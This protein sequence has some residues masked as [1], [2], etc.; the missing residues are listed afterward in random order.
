MKISRWIYPVLLISIL[1]F[2]MTKSFSQ[3]SGSDKL[4]NGSALTVTQWREDADFLQKEILRLHPDPFYKNPNFNREKFDWMFAELRAHLDTWHE[5]KIITE[6]A[7]IIGSINDGHTAIDV[8]GTPPTYYSF[9]Y[10]PLFTYSFPEGLYVIGAPDAHKALIGQKIVAVNHTGIEEIKKKI[11]PL[12][13]SDYGNETSFKDGLRF[14][15]VVSQYLHG[16]DIIQDPNKATFTFEDAKGVQTHVTFASGSM[17]T[18][19]SAFD[20]SGDIGKPLYRQQPMKYYWYQFLEDQNA[21]YIKYTFEMIDKELSPEDFCR[22]LQAVVDSKNPSRVILDLRQN[23]GGN[24]GTLN[25]LYQFLTQPS[26]NQ[27]GKLIV[28]MDRRTQSAAT[29]L[30]IRLGMISR[31]IRIG[32]PAVSAVNFFDNDRKFALPNSKLRI[33]ISTHFQMA[34]FPIDTRTEF[35]ADI[36]MEITAQDFFSMKDPMLELALNREFKRDQTHEHDH[37]GDP[38]TSEHKEGNHTTRA[39][40]TGY[41]QYTPWQVLEIRKDGEKLRMLIEDGTNVNFLNTILYPQSNRKFDTD[42]NEV[43]VLFT[44]NELTLHTPWGDMTLPKLAPGYRS[45]S[46]LVEAGEVD[47]AVA[48]LNRIHK[49]VVTGFELKNLESRI[50][51]FGYQLVRTQNFDGALK[52]FNLNSQLF[53]QSA[54]VW[55]S[56][57]EAYAIMGN[58]EAAIHCY[59]KA[60]KIAPGLISATQALEKLK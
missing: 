50:N 10:F 34:G 35:P 15:I 12:V 41:Y 38:K 24:I 59:N 37:H 23:Q 40:V 22:R 47:R 30:A 36:P 32:E 6:I 9:S 19:F 51:S 53:P 3:H 26:V 25:P 52:L 58:K 33:G 5:D 11:R 4:V 13:S 2:S 31:A 49:M 29:V 28:L 44:E 55:D 21:L 46:Q 14:S 43:T 45:L 60:L 39:S 48:E 57:G 1:S 42:I 54:N 17:Q 8:F 20:R 18:M 56:L 7:R 27:F 16:L